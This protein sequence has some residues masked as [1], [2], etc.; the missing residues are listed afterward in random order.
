[1]LPDSPATT[2]SY[3]T[4]SIEDLFTD[5]R[6]PAEP[7]LVETGLADR[8]PDMTIILRGPGRSP[9]AELRLRVIHDREPFG[10]VQTAIAISLVP[11]IGISDGHAVTPGPLHQPLI[12]LI[13][14]S[15]IDRLNSDAPEW[16]SLPMPEPVNIG[17]LT[18]GSEA[19][20]INPELLLSE[21]RR[22]VLPLTHDLIEAL[23]DG[24]TMK[25]SP[26]ISYPI[27]VSARAQSV[28]ELTTAR[29]VV[30]EIQRTRLQYKS[31]SPGARLERSEW[32][33]IVANWQTMAK[34]CTTQANFEK[35]VSNFPTCLERFSNLDGAERNALSTGFAQHAKAVFIAAE[36]AKQPAPRP[37]PKRAPVAVKE[38][39]SLDEV[40]EKLAATRRDN[41]AGAG[42][43]EADIER[44][45]G[46]WHAMVKLSMT[47]PIVDSLCEKFAAAIKRD[48]AMKNMP[49][50][51]RDAFLI[52]FVMHAQEVL[53]R[54][55][56]LQPEAA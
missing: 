28:E 30:N 42:F 54:A 1:M 6:F 38:L 24:V 37:A 7:P 9:D 46:M 43:T 11:D 52:G 13:S 15:C 41:A 48:P 18:P 27:P 16:A 2:S 34:D 47:Q 55:P 50:D 12:D 29:S 23:G 49:E 17:Y 36:A 14:K 40:K 19:A 31:L 32:K 3:G 4:Q 20:R 26:R 25:K 39:A 21:I 44:I 35:A 33:E 5:I 53:N 8:Q 56:R 10:Q 22:A 45:A 51:E